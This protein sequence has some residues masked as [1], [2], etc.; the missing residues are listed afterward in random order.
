MTLVGAALGLW[1]VVALPGPARAEALGVPWLGSAD[2]AV[3]QSILE[4]EVTGVTRALPE[5]GASFTITATDLSNGICRSFVVERPDAVEEGLACRAASGGWSARNSQ[6]G[7]LS[8]ADTRALLLDGSPSAGDVRRT[9]YDPAGPGRGSLQVQVARDPDTGEVRAI[10]LPSD[11]QAPA[12]A[13]PGLPVEL[14]DWDMVVTTV[15]PPVLPSR[16]PMRESGS[17]EP[18]GLADLVEHAVPAIGGSV[19]PLV[20]VPPVQPGR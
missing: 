8:A 15:T 14:A 7:A 6:G 2:D 9:V 13:P 11:T 4:Y 3:I 12:D 19:E 16:H 10:T 5:S 17:P 1:A 20:P 18:I